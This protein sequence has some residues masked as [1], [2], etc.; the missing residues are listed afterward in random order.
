MLMIADGCLYELNTWERK[1]R[2]WQQGILNRLNVVFISLLILP[3]IF[4]SAA[5]TYGAPLNWLKSKA[6]ALS[7]A[8]REG[9]I[10][11]LIAGR[12]I[13]GNTR[14]MQNICETD[15]PV[16]ALIDQHFIPW[17]CD[18]DSSKEWY[19]YAQGFSGSFD[20][21]LICCI[22]PSNNSKFLDRSTGKQTA[23]DFL[24]RLQSIIKGLP[25]SKKKSR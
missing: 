21:P 11:L 16:R 23:T 18:M 3:C 7:I 1:M 6:Q 2:T 5:I 14:R 13:C 9:K 12:D 25:K 24:S 10:I 4:L 19:T 17:Y 8:K 15:I 20:L 22:N